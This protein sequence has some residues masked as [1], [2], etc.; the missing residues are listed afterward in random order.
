MKATEFERLGGHGWNKKWKQS[1]RVVLSDGS[2]GRNVQVRQTRRIES[3]LRAHTRPAGYPTLCHMC[4]KILR[5]M[6]S[7]GLD[8]QKRHQGTQT[9][10]H[11]GQVHGS[12]TC[13]AAHTSL[14][15]PSLWASPE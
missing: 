12:C 1:L 6:L 4:T 5:A 14:D 8:G 11:T 2:V 3:C 15:L 9:G 7:T 10:A 13:P